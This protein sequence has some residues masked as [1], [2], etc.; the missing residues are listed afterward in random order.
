MAAE[1][2]V[3][4]EF[5]KRYKRAPTSDD[6][7]SPAMTALIGDAS[8]KE[9]LARCCF[10]PDPIPGTEKY[11]RMFPDGNYLSKAL[12]AEEI[13][14]LFFQFQVIC[15]ELGPREQTLLT[16]PNVLRMWVERVKDAGWSMGPLSSLAW[17]DLAELCLYSLTRIHQ[18]ESTSP[19]DEV[20]S[21]PLSSASTGE[22]DPGN[23][24]EPTT[25]SGGSV[26]L[27]CLGTPAIS[28]EELLPTESVAKAAE[29]FI[30]KTRKQTK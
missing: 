12:S 29:K 7:S 8:G 25:S 5:E 11:I 13:A 30:R 24:V 21:Q 2:V 1:Q 23:S 14:V 26:S 3:R 27:T 22:S 10:E 6:L 17:L 9:L 15:L 4:E 19:G 16:N 18:L 20:D 28:A